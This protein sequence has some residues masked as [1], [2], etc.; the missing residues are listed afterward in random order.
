M[1]NMIGE[2]L[3]SPRRRVV[4]SSAVALT[5]GGDAIFEPFDICKNQT[6]LKYET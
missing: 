5:G 4:K 6:A 1:N 2:E 3:I